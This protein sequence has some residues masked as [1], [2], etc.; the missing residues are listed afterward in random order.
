MKA[1]QDW[2]GSRN[3]AVRRGASRGPQGRSRSDA[4]RKIG[5]AA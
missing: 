5:E 3:D 2:T 4:G 1:C